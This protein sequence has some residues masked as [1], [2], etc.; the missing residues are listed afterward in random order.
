[1]MGRWIIKPNP[2]KDEYIIWSS[3]VDN[4][5]SDVLTREGMLEHLTAPSFWPAPWARC[6]VTEHLDRAD[7]FGTS[8]PLLVEKW[9]AETLLNN[10]EGLDCEHSY[11]I[12]FNA[13]ADFTRAQ[14]SN[15]IET[16][17][18]LCTICQED[19]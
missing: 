14:Q 18:R 3:I 7:T 12:S 16:L 6:E 1:M 9:G 19:E 13:L 17:K 10:V 5:I 2:D 11:L 8:N 15:D 4:V